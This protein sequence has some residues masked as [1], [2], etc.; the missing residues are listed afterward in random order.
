[1]PIIPLRD[2]NKLERIPFQFVTVTLIVLCVLTYLYQWL[3]P[4]SENQ[5]DALVLSFA[6][7]PAVLTGGVALP[8]KLDAVPAWAT[9]ITYT[10]LHG[11]FLH[12]LGNMLFLWVF[13]DNVE[14]QLGHIRFIIFYFACGAI[15]ALCHL[16][17]DPSSVA[18]LI[19]ASGAISGV[20]GAYLVLH[21]KTRVWVLLFW[22]I[23]LPLPAWLVLGFWICFQVYMA[24]TVSSAPGADGSSVAWLAHIGGFFAGILL[25]LPFRKRPPTTGAIQRMR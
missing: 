19:G 23:P 7:I 1:M 24:M 15:A 9:L 18:P 20:M 5:S 14:D 11:G 6:M 2:I 12:L 13:G 10:F 21:P 8:A 22:R 4:A 16:V 17:L 3:A 25:I